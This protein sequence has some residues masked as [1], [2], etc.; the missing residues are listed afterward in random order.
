MVVGHGLNGGSWGTGNNIFLI[1]VG[2][3]WC[4]NYTLQH[5]WFLCTRNIR[6]DSFN[7]VSDPT[8]LSESRGNKLGFTVF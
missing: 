8:S 2:A 7:I 3:T 4:L 5:V 1:L 6:R